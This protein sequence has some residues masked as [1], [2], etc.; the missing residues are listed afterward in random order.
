MKQ[1]ASNENNLAKSLLRD[2]YL[3]FAEAGKAMQR[4]ANNPYGIFIFD[5]IRYKQLNIKFAQDQ[6]QVLVQG[7]HELL[8]RIDNR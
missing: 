8:K 6:Y 7:Q 4:Q 3:D 5:I 1:S 2:P